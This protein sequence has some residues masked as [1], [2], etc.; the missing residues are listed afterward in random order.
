MKV[1]QSSPIITML[2]VACLAGSALAQ[3]GSSARRLYNPNTEITVKGTVEKVTEIGRQGWTG[4][5]LTLRTNEQ[6]YD[7]HVGPSAYVAKSGFTFSAGNQIEV[8]GSKLKFGGADAI[9]AREIKKD[10]KVLTLRDRQGIP[11]W[12]RGP[13]RT[14]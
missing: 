12:S 1:T 13:R 8:T 14:G 5:H 6:T 3:M 11:R 7:V 2:L 10:G 9:V 4:T